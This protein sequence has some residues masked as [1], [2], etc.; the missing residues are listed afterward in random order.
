MGIEAC[1][2]CD[3]SRKGFPK[4]IAIAKSA[5]TSSTCIRDDSRYKRKKE[6]LYVEKIQKL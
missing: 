5:L 1:G 3:T 2:T 6:L 4:D